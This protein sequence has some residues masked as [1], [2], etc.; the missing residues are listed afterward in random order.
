MQMKLSWKRMS[1]AVAIGLLTTLTGPVSAAKYNVMCVKTNTGN[2]YPVVRVSM[3]VVPDGGKNFEIVLK[4]GQGEANVESITFEKHQEELNF[5]DYKGDPNTPKDP[6]LTKKIYL[7]TSTGK[8]WTVSKMPQLTSK[9]GSSKMDVVVGSETEHDVT[10]VWF[11]RGDKV[12]E[13]LGID[14]LS[15]TDA[16]ERLQLQ[17]PISSQLYISGCGNATKAILYSAGGQQMSTSVV[18]N[19]ATTVYVGDLASGVY[20]IK[21]GKKSLK[22]IKK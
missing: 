20:I 7:L 9:E 17:T 4:D 18:V 22:F 11:Y 12:D 15:M 5:N 6:D 3:M 14:G 2:Y 16:E 10:A 8:Y 13:A 1:L 19:G 21:V